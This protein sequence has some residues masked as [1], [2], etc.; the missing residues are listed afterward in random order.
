MHRI[1]T[2]WL[3]A[4]ALCARVSTPQTDIVNADRQIEA[5]LRGSWLWSRAESLVWKI[6]AA[7]LDSR[8]RRLLSYVNARVSNLGP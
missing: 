4:E 5:I 8:L 2:W 3:L 1:R 6:H 7:W